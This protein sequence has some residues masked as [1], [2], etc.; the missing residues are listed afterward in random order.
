M[1]KGRAKDMKKSINDKKYVEIFELVF[2][3]L[4]RLFIYVK[5]DGKKAELVLKSRSLYK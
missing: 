1:N 2:S 4:S 5:F 3:K